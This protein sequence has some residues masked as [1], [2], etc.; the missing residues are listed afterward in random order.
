MGSFENVK[1][2]A[3]DNLL[4]QES[5]DIIDLLNKAYSNELL[6]WLVY[7]HAA[8]FMF[9]HAREKFILH[10]QEHATEE[11]EHAR[12]VGER[13]TA[14]GEAP[15]IDM[16]IL[17][18]AGFDANSVESILTLIMQ[19]EGEA[20]TL[21]SSMLT[22]LEKHAAMRAKIEEIVAVEQEHFEDFEKM[23]RDQ[24]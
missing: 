23:L 19:L 13:L 6:T 17:K 8:H 9:G 2:T 7:E 1:I 4:L 5:P 18:R 24:S 11:A 22:K 14:L 12:W 21:Y 3:M 10:F 20:V 15:V 16:K